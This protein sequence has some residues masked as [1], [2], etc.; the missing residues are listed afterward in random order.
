VS[1]FSQNHH[2]ARFAP[3]SIAVLETENQPTGRKE[4]IPRAF[5]PGFGS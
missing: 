4:N 2:G 5:L 1:W 3:S